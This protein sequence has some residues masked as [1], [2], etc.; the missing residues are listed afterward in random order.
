MKAECKAGLGVVSQD[1]KQY[2]LG[3]T[4]NRKLTA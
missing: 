3:S 1:S 4:G 2:H